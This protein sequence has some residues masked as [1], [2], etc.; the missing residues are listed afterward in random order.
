MADIAEE[1]AP[2]IRADGGLIGAEDGEY[3]VSERTGERIVDICVGGCLFIAAA[4]N[5]IDFACGL[6]ILRVG[7]CLLL[8]APECAGA[9]GGW[10]KKNAE[11]LVFIPDIT[12]GAVMTAI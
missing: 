8:G 11:I 6:G 5:H 2:R 9:R 3:G 1:G 7:E 12:S 10:A 4:A